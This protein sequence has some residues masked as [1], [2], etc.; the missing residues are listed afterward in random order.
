[1]KTRNH[2]FAF[3]QIPLFLGR[4]FGVECN[5]FGYKGDVTI[6]LV[7]L[8]DLTTMGFIDTDILDCFVINVGFLLKPCSEVPDSAELG[9]ENV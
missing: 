6:D 5:E 8:V 3:R 4:H 9:D 2:R 1:M 7:D